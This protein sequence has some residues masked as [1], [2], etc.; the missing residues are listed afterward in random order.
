MTFLE[1]ASAAVALLTYLPLC[2][3]ILRGNTKQNMATF[4]LWGLLDAVVA[5]SIILQ[6]GNFALPL[7]Y[8][9]GAFAVV[10]CLFTVRYLKWTR[11]ETLI[12]ALVFVCIVVW[13]TVGSEMATLVSTLAM[14]IASIPQI[15]DTW[16]KP[17]EFPMLSY[18]GFS[19]A[20]F[21]GI[22]AGENWSIAERLYPTT[23]TVLTVML[24]L[25]SMRKWRKALQKKPVLRIVE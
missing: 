4:I 6:R 5:G 12:S 23:C 1:K 16:K 11:F 20:N 22:L 19:T 13:T 10:A 25:M 15:V 17:L 18:V 3:G 8:T 14:V 7:F 21:L 2:W 24:V 9:I